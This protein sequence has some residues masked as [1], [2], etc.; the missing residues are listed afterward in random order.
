MPFDA[1]PQIFEESERQ[2]VRLIYASRPAE[3]AARRLTETVGEILAAAHRHNPA[4]GVTGLLL[5]HERAFVQVLE[6][7]RAGVRTTWRRIERDQRHLSPAVRSMETIAERGFPEWSLCARFLAQI[8]AAVLHRLGLEPGFD[9]L[10]QPETTLMALLV[11]VC[12]AQ[13]H[14]LG[15]EIQAHRA[16]LTVAA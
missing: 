4:H 6:G 12:R 10:L 5:A 3:P 15:A 1:R 13:E 16:R 14:R 11:S 2:L 7:P 9:P 8:D